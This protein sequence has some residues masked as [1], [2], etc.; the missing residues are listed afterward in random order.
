MSWTATHPRSSPKGTQMGLCPDVWEGDKAETASFLHGKS[1]QFSRL[2]A[3]VQRRAPAFT[4]TRFQNRNEWSGRRGSGCFS[5]ALVSGRGVDSMMQL[6]MSE[7]AVLPHTAP[8]DTGQHH[9]PPQCA[10]PRRGCE[11]LKSPLSSTPSELLP[12]FIVW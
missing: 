5:L 2:A 11:P 4:S 1:A 7:P 3:P 8:G 6:E 9:S 12:I 10:A